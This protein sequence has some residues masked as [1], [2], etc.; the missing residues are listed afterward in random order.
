GHHRRRRPMAPGRSWYKPPNPPKAS[1]K[2]RARADAALSS[3]VVSPCPASWLSR[4]EAVANHLF[5]LT[6]RRTF[7]RVIKRHGAQSNPNRTDIHEQEHCNHQFLY[8]T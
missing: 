7:G 5:Y 6:T 2:S 1:G 8:F 4:P 3:S